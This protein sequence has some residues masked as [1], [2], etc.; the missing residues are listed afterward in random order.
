MREAVARILE[1]NGLAASATLVRGL[2]PEAV[3]VA[4]AQDDK[5]TRQMLEDDAE[6]QR[7][8]WRER[9]AKYQA[10]KSRGPVK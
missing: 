1:D 2:I 8:G 6:H 7:A 4:M 9:T 5:W 3:R 10:K